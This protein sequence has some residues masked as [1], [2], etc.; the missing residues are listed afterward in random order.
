MHPL[1]VVVFLPVNLLWLGTKFYLLILVDIARY[2]FQLY[3]KNL[4]LKTGFEC[5][6]YANKKKAIVLQRQPKSEEEKNGSCI[7]LSKKKLQKT[8]MVLILLSN[9]TRVA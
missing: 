1:L 2:I 4:S 6:N 5:A 3:K 9:I 7:N 8:E